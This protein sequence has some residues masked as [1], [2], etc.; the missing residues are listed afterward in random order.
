MLLGLLAYKPQFG[1]LLPLA[2]LAGGYW[3]ATGVAIVTVLAAFALTL[4]AFGLEPWLAFRESLTFS[5][6]VVLEAGGAGYFR[7]QSAFA[8]VRL[9]G[10]GTGAAYSVQAI[11][12]LAMA[13][14][15]LRTWRSPV[16]FRLKAA[17]LIGAS[18]L[19]TPYLFDY[20]L[21]LLAPAGAFFIAYGLQRGFVA[22]EKSALAAI[23]LAPL[24]ARN[25]AD[26]TH[27]PL[28]C[29]SLLA[30][31]VLVLRRAESDRRSLLAAAPAGAGKLR[32]V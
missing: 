1:L 5:R 24:V 8:A 13:L 9:M 14:A 10:G 12:T 32:H 2:L 3:R 29:L 20:D 4:W 25:V 21:V 23:A 18:L 28:G 27:I 26:W 31:A 17:L 15:V 19:S 22:G 30:F 16:D 7:L 11:V 6:E